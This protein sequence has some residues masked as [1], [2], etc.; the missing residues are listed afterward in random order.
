MQKP[1]DF[2]SPVGQNR[3]RHR[4][5]QSYGHKL[6]TGRVPEF[7]H[8]RQLAGCRLPFGADPSH[9]LG[10]EL[11]HAFHQPVPTPTGCKAYTGCA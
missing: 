11:S 8:L 4:P 1:G 3:V 9:D 7:V 5:N 10:G 2:D 6:L